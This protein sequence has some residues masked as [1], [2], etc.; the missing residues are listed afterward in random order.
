M[1]KVLD[2]DMVLGLGYQALVVGLNI[3]ICM[4]LMT[5][6]VIDTDIIIAVVKVIAPNVKT[7]SEVT[8]IKIRVYMEVTSYIKMSSPPA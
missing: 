6:F 5:D 8:Y 7:W 1:D 2:M 4:V 3:P